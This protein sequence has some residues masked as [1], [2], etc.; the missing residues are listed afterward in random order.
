MHVV[1]RATLAVAGESSSGHGGWRTHTHTHAYPT[2]HHRTGLD[3]RWPRDT[4]QINS[5]VH[6]VRPYLDGFSAQLC[7]AS[8]PHITYVRRLPCD[9]HL[10]QTRVMMAR[11]TGPRMRP[12]HPI[13]PPP[14]PK[15]KHVAI[16]HSPANIKTPA[17]A[18]S[19]RP[20][21]RLV[22][23]CALLSF[24]WQKKQD[25]ATG[26]P[27]AFRTMRDDARIAPS[28]AE[29]SWCLLINRPLPTTFPPLL[30]R[31][32]TVHSTV[33]VLLLANFLL[34]APL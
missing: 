8:Q 32:K 33:T 30:F 20:K 13:P 15:S 25:K 2:P 9:K 22:M 26:N 11:K 18:I 17:P 1:V 24:E 14:R 21:T 27:P 28:P 29:L 31:A 19:P 34:A 6:T 10:H 5:R 16:P 23:H 3:D 12:S 7:S 4:E